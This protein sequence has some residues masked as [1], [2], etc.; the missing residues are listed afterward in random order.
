MTELAGSVAFRVPGSGGRAGPG[1][2]AL[3][4]TKERPAKTIFPA[5]REAILFLL[6]WRIVSKW[7]L[8]WAQEPHFKTEFSLVVECATKTPRYSVSFSQWLVGRFFKM[9]EMLRL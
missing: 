4:L 1:A 8:T 6:K 5:H 2:A 3:A 9:R 7:L